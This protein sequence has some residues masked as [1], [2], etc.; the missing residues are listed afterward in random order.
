MGVAA[1]D[2]D[3]DGR[4]D[5][6][7]TNFLARNQYSVHSHAGR[8]LQRSYVSVGLGAPSLDELGFGTQFL[9]VDNDGALDRVP[10]GA[11]VTVSIDNRRQVFQLTAGDGY[12]CS[13][14]RRSDMTRRPLHQRVS[15]SITCDC[16]VQE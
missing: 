3:H 15:S 14:E 11:Q 9:D 1:G 16:E 12:H 5:L 7:V 8:I 4:L 10:I 13:N 6:L 2:V